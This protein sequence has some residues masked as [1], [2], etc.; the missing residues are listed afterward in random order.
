MY[1]NATFL[2]YSG[3][4]Q[5]ALP[6][7]GII[8]RQSL[9]NALYTYAGIGL[10]ALLTLLLYPHILRPEEYGLTRVLISASMIGAQFA[11]LGMRNTVIRYFP[12]FDRTPGRSE[13]LLFL[14]L[15]VPLAGFLLFAI[16]F[17]L[18]Q[19][20]IVGFYAERSP[21]LIDYLIYV[22][23]LTLFI[24]YFE[25]LNSYLR[26]L[27]DST[28]G[29][30]VSEVILRLLVIAA[31]GLHF[32]EWI[33]FSLFLLLFAAAYG[34]Q[35]LLLMFTLIRM[36]RFRP[37]P[38]FSFLRSSLSRGMAGYGLYTLLGGLTTVVVWN[39]DIM[40][41]GSMEGLGQTAVYAVAFYIGTVIAVP[42]RAIERIATPLLARHIHNREW[43]E[44]AS[45]YRNS[46]LV[47][48]AAGTFILLLVWAN[49]DPLLE[50]LPEVY[51][52]GSRVVLI[53][54]IGKLFDMATGT[55][56]S[57]ILTSRHYRFD[58]AANLLLVVFTVGLNLWLIPL[59][60]IE[61]AAAATALSILLYNLIKFLYVAFR[62]SM[63]PFRPAHLG[64]AGLA[65]LSVLAVG[66]LPDLPL[67]PNLL[68]TGL[69][70][71]LTFLLPVWKFGLAGEY[72]LQESLR[73]GS[74]NGAEA[75]EG[76][77]ARNSPDK[78]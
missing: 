13:G 47:Q 40:M 20:P 32:F 62:L 56:G 29:S 60:G 43:S 50:L 9:T 63:Q 24:L 65:L 22:L 11:H 26:S 6:A 34:L 38:D 45:I 37:L 78:S 5:P 2:Y 59:Y 36:G 8:A 54:G 16:L 64:L 10:G 48:T 44:V 39:V 17:W 52:E 57:I 67:L 74:Q 46:S 55:N 23:P 30:L 35:P 75:D 19:D 18:F 51:S 73:S 12:F 41:L 76:E 27:R 1:S 66:A 61:G 3:E 49:T 14:A 53:I 71:S 21:L 77:S 31:L 28:T 33:G 15:A 72:A 69:A 25:I 42:Q 70:V 58:L 4:Q 7:L 68:V